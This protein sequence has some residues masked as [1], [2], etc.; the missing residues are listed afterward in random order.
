M[1]ARAVS[2]G[3]LVGGNKLLPKGLTSVS[4]EERKHFLICQ[5][6]FW[7]IKL[8]TLQRLLLNITGMLN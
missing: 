8:R 2:D 5:F 4:P 3:N 6:S 7:V 1:L